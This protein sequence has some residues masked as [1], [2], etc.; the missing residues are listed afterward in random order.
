MFATLVIALPS[1]HT[2]GDL[3]VRLRDEEQTLKTQGLC[4]FDY[5]YLAWYADVNHSESEIESG[6]RLVLTYDLIHR[7]ATSSRSASVLDDHKQNLEKVLALWNKQD[8]DI[9]SHSD[10]L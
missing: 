8:R 3:V 2:G 9:E 1:E 4:D 10:P 6:H 7:A 5:S